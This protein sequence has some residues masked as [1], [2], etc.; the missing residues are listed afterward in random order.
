MKRQSR[1]LKKNRQKTVENTKA[2]EDKLP[3]K[4]RRLFLRRARNGAVA[5]GLISGAAWL[6][7]EEVSA[8]VQEHNLSRIGNGIASVVQIHDPQCPKCI[9]LQRETREALGA[10]EDGELQYLIA[11][12]RSDEG[13][14][15]A[16]RQGVQH[17]T[18]MLFDADGKRRSVFAGPNRAQ[19]LERIF[20]NHV[21]RNLLLDQ[22]S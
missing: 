10:F 14:Q 20:R 9:A 5:V 4:N 21:D 8:S 22:G 15:F 2:V 12:I 17:V 13:R 7:A 19:D 1:K 3:S 16:T 11:N 18:L 6:V